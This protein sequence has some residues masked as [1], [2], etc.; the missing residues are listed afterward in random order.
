MPDYKAL[1]HLLIEPLLSSASLQMDVETTCGGRKV[2][3]RLA[4]D[5]KDRGRV[6]GR[7]GRT[8]QAIRQVMMAAAQLAG[9]SLYIDIYGEAGERNREERE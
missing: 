8:L 1:V 9:Q 7:G 6:F 3:L 2:W 5:P 4:F